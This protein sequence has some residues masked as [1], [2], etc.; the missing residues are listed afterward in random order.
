MKKLTENCLSVITPRPKI[1]HKGTFG[2]VVLIGGDHQYGGAIIM[3]AEAC[4][5]AG[6]GLVTVVTDHRNHTA[7]HT[8][9][10]EA[11]VVDWED[12][13][14]LNSVLATADICLIGP[15][16]GLS[17]KSL[18]LLT[19]VLAS[20]KEKQWFIIDG[21]AITLLA[22]NPLKIPFPKQVV[23][24]PHQMEWQRLSGLTIKHQ[25]PEKNLEIQN[26]LN[27]IIV[28]KSHQTV[29]YSQLGVFQNPLG[30]P[31]MATGGTGDTLAG[32]IAGFLAQFPRE[33]ET[34][35]AAVYLH[36]YIGDLLS[37][38]RYVVLPTEISAA[39]PYWMKYFADRC[40]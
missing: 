36:S 3:A 16:L 4:L 33:I 18:A 19:H 23:F 40:N 38:E 14:T 13:T 34:I 5:K 37:K 29:I 21:S 28:L 39:L 12:Q 17:E 2:R 22:E 26:K 24:T 1:S 6:A 11:M 15:G 7:L 32:I 8:R 9:L 27:N 20:Q 10:P 25:T 35:H 30:N 31:A